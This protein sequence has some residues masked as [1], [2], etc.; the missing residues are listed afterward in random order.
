MAIPNNL[1]PVNISQLSASLPDETS[2]DNTQEFSLLNNILPDSYFL[3]GSFEQIQEVA[4]HRAQQVINASQI[5]RPT[6]SIPSRIPRISPKLPSLA[7][8]KRFINARINNIK[9][10]RQQAS[11]RALKEELKQ[12]ENPFAYRQS[13]INKQANE[14]IA[15]RLKNQ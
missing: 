2:R 10:E 7:Q 5:T 1:I 14:D 8:I 15:R 11:L 3:S 12:R 9:L 6:F 4:L 13:L